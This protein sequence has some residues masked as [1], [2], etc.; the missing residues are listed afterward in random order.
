VLAQAVRSLPPATAKFIVCPIVPARAEAFLDLWRAVASERAGD[1][2]IFPFRMQQ[3]Y[4]E[5]MA[6]ATYCVMPSLHEPFGAATEP[7]LQGSPVVAHATGG[8]VQQVIDAR[9]NPAEATGILYRP[10]EVGTPE[11]QGRQWRAVL[12]SPDPAS[13]MHFPLYVSLVQGLAAAL[14]EAIRIFQDDTPLYG[15]M[16]ARLYPQATKFDWDRA[17]A[18]YGQIYDAAVRTG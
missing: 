2:V 16:L 14:T 12:D 1:V 11:Q 5:S 13:R 18:E 4:L 3:G 7:Y 9:Q 15:Q 10:Q 17:A 8:L 6:G